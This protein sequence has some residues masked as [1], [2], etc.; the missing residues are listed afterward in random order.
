MSEFDTTIVP[1]ALANSADAELRAFRT[2][3]EG[4]EG[5]HR[6]FMI[7]LDTDS[8]S[9][10]IS[11]PF[12][13]EATDAEGIVSAIDE[14]IDHAESVVANLREIREGYAD[15][16]GIPGALGEVAERLRQSISKP[17]VDAL[18]YG[19]DLMWNSDRKMTRDLREG[20]MTLGMPKEH[21][22]KAI[23]SFRRA[24]AGDWMRQLRNA[25]AAAPSD[26]K[27]ETSFTT[28]LAVAMD[29]VKEVA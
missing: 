24:T 6:I 29:E 28:K 23:N 15:N 19:L 17:H 11:Q 1:V 8:L 25:A 14:A 26:L 21:R 16:L 5:S 4:D 12:D 22:G 27:S 9:T 20:L 2:Y 10:S 7:E 18:G 13:A 3:I